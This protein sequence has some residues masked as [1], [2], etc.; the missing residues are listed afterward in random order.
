M[1]L[2]THNRLVLTGFILVY[3]GGMGALGALSFDTYGVMTIKFVLLPIALLGLG[4]IVV[5][6]LSPLKTNPITDAFLPI[7]TPSSAPD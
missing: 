5:A 7:V 2:K 4:L 1:S 6:K 3:F